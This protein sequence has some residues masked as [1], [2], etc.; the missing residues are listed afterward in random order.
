MCSFPGNRLTH[1]DITI[2]KIF[3]APFINNK[4]LLMTNAAYWF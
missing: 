2:R 3:I 1:D 4:H